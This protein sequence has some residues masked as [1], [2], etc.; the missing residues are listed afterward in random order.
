[1]T[2]VAALAFLTMC[3]TVPDPDPTPVSRVPFKEQCPV[4]KPICIRWEIHPD[5]LK[6][7]KV[8][9]ETKTYDEWVDPPCVVV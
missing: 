8:M 9:S 2:R 5:H 1:V 4:Q 3:S 6:C 7:T